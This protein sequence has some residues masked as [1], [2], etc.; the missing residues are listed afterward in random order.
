M[1]EHDPEAENRLSEKIMLEPKTERRYRI[2]SMT[3]P[4]IALHARLSAGL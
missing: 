3:A 4:R 1:R 2:A